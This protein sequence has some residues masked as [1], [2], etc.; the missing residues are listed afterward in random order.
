[1]G[2]GGRAK[3][4][5]TPSAAE[6]QKPLPHVGRGSGNFGLVGQSFRKPAGLP[7]DLLQV[8]PDRK[9]FPVAPQEAELRLPVLKQAVR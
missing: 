4:R 2:D 8:F 6:I 9:A 5:P 3:A 7:V 1:M